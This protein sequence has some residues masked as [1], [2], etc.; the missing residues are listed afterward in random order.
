[1]GYDL[2]M[3]ELG[4]RHALRRIARRGLAAGAVGLAIL[5]AGSACRSV[6]G[7]TPAG[8]T[9]PSIEYTNLFPAHPINPLR[10]APTDAHTAACETA[11]HQAPQIPGHEAAANTVK[12]C[13]ADGTLVAH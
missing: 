11:L 8:P 10:P 12:D 5:G 13:V 6:D 7:T 4:S 2:S 1:M 9:P 3:K